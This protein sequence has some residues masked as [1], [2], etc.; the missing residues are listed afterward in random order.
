MNVELAVIKG[1]ILRLRQC[2]SPQTWPALGLVPMLFATGPAA[3][4]KSF[5]AV[6][7]GGGLIGS[8]LL[9]L[10]MLPLQSFRA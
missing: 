2:S 3:K 7:I 6:V 10:F 8:T 4:F 1:A 9:T 5:A